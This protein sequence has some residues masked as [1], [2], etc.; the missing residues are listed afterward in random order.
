MKVTKTISTSLALCLALGLTACGKGYSS[1]G[2]DGS[3]S[4]S[5]SQVNMESL[6]PEI[7]TLE[8]D[9]AS[10]QSE[11]G[12][13]SILSLTTST[14][15]TAATTGTSIQ[16]K[17]TQALDKVIAA[18]NTVV[19]KKKEIRAKIEG[20]AAKLDPNNAEH[21]KIR[22]KIDEM[23]SYLDQ[24]DAKLVQV[25]A[26]VVNTIDAKVLQ[27]DE[28]LAKLSASNPVTIIASIAWGTL[29][30]KIVELRDKIAAIQL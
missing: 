18:I 12:K 19:A 3:A 7:A 5:L 27:I 13:L 8:T 22:A 14:P 26:T 4:Q 9:M 20:I 1:R 15:G 23:L 24:L 2:S 6:E 29:K 10:A 11:I 21:V 25:R 30:T 28:A 16:D 17:I